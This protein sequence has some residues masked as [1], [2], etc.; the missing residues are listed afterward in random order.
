MP[1][2]LPEWDS[3]F[4]FVQQVLHLTGHGRSVWPMK[5]KK[6]FLYVSCYVILT[7]S[8]LDSFSF[9]P[10]KLRSMAPLKTPRNIWLKVVICELRVWCVIS[11]Y[12]DEA[13]C[14]EEPSLTSVCGPSLSVIAGLNF[15][16]ARMSVSFECCVLSGR[17]PW[18]RPIT[19][20]GEY[21]RICVCAPLSMIRCN[22]NPRHLKW[23]CKWVRNKKGIKETS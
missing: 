21:Y 11:R 10:N 9:L 12:R 14:W 16:A 4:P 6:C 23:L 5:V 8:D 2:L 22:K 13:V 18:V 3:V 15:A 7:V 20:P 19:H 17:G 1:I